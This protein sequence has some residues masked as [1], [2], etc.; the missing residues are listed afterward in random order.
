[1]IVNDRCVQICLLLDIH[2]NHLKLYT[3]YRSIVSL[4]NYNVIFMCV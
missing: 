1:M 2:L 4:V 3:L